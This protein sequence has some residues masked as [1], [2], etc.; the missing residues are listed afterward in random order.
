ML[1]DLLN[2]GAKAQ[3]YKDYRTDALADSAMTEAH[4]AFLSHMEAVSFGNTNEVL[5]DLST[6][7][8]TW[9]GKSLNLDSKVELKFVFNPSA[10]MG[11]VQDLSLHV[12]YED[13]TGATVTAVLRD[14][15]A[16]GTSNKLYSFTFD[17]LLA[18]ELRS[19]VSVQIF[20]GNSPLSCT[21]R[22]SADAYG[23]N[24]SGDLLALCQ[25]LFAYSDS[26]KS[27]FTK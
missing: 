22:Y 7:V 25:A 18:A 11:E 23:N 15:E 14:P 20:E 1:V 16:Y 6:P 2:Y 24:K 12:S 10:Y 3:L 19:V 17:G 13:I 27:F 21:L 26:A 4:K 5:K 9:A 8:I